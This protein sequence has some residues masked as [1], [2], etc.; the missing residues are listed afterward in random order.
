MKIVQYKDQMAKFPLAQLVY[1][2]GGHRFEWF[3]LNAGPGERAG[4]IL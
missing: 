4:L 1:Q 2:P 3:M